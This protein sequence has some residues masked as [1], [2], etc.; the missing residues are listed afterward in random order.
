MPEEQSVYGN[1]W[2]ARLNV[3]LTKVLHWNQLGESNNDVYCELLKRKVGLDSVFAYQRNSASNQ[4]VIFVEAKTIERLESLSRAKI[5]GW[6]TD[7]LEK[8]INAPSSH[9]FADK[10]RPHSNADCSQGLIALWVRN[11][12]G[13]SDE[14]IQAWLG[15]LNLPIRRQN[16]VNIIFISNHIISKICSIHQTLQ[17]LKEKNDFS[18][19]SFHFPTYGNFPVADGNCIPMEALLSKFLFCQAKRMQI[20][21]GENRTSEYSSPIVFY[22]GHINDYNDLRF[23]G[24]ALRQFQILKP[25]TEIGVY[26]PDSIVRFRNEIKTFKSEFAESGCTCDFHE[27]TFSD[28]LPGWLA[29]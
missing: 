16:P 23:I 13:Y 4:Q 14:K 2:N 1:D 26:I 25:N 27:F 24:L 18:E 29:E 3:F 11:A 15:Q 10:Y 7:F 9:D 5:E 6:V 28:E 8:I 21:K 12:D 20:I 19:I 17:Y 22:T